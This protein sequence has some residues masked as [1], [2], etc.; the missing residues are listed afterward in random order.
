MNETVTA[1][2]AIVIP[3]RSFESWNHFMIVTILRPSTR[4]PSN[5]ERTLVPS[6][7]LRV[8]GAHHLRSISL[9]AWPRRSL[10][11]R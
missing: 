1:N 11:R 5:S 3:M 6:S 2:V 8:A 4:S 10:R 7:A 9:G